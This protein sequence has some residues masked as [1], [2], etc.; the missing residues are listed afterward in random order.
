MNQVV[1]SALISGLSVAIPSVIA[2]IFTNKRN[3]ELINYQIKELKTEVEKHNK[4]IERV[5]KLE[6][7]VDDLE[8]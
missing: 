8:K 1:L 2:T 4:V 5:F 7:R 6:Q 3:N